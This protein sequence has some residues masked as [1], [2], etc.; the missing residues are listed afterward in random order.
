M[1]DKDL[2]RFGNSSSAGLTVVNNP[3]PKETPLTSEE[4]EQVLQYLNARK[5]S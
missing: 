3:A 1:T 4:K 2:S 5:K